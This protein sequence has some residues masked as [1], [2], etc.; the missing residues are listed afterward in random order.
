MQTDG[1]EIYG[2]MVDYLQEQ[3]KYG[4]YDF[5]KDAEY[6]SLVQ[7]HIDQLGEKFD[8]KGLNVS[9]IATSNPFT[10]CKLLSDA[11]C[12]INLHSYH[13]IVI[14]NKEVFELLPNVR[15]IKSNIFIDDLTNDIS[16]ADIVLYPDYEYYIPLTSINYDLSDKNVVVVNCFKDRPVDLEIKQPNIVKTT[17]EFKDSIGIKEVLDCNCIQYKNKRHYY[18]ISDRKESDTVKFITMKW[19]T[20]YGPE[21]VNRLYNSIKRTYSGSFKFFCVTDD[22]TGI[23]P[24]IGILSFDDIGFVASDCFTIQ[25]M[26]L[27]KKD[28]LPFKGPYAVLDLDTL[29]ISDMKPYFDEYEFKEPR[30]IKNYWEDIEGCLHLTFFGSCWLNS[31]FVTWTDDQLD[32]VYQFY[33]DNKDR[34]E[35]KYGDLDWFL[36]C[37]ILDKL[38]FHPPKTVYAYSFGA[39][40]PDDMEKYK[41]RDDYLMVIF[42]TSHGEGKELHEADGWV[43]ELWT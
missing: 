29:I 26:F 34:I 7:K 32:F 20:K 25:K 15:V 38:L 40:Y 23:D 1:Q 6:I 13:P 24:S 18:F 5:L 27:F 33:Q 42:N 41:K 30:F 22:S 16:N 19:G 21:Y 37:T 35:W 14:N 2:L 10:W 39:H 3:V 28:C 36:W 9:V 17:D 8:L 43:K 31:S 4:Y 12:I 11:G